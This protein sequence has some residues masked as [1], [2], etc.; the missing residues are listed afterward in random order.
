MSL[1]R[2]YSKKEILEAYLNAV[3]WGNWGAME[4]RG[5]REASRYYLG[6]E[7]EKADPAGIALLVG[8][9]PAPNAY[10]PYHSPEKAL[11][12][13]SFVLRKM[14]KKGI[15]SAKETALALAQPLPVKRPPVQLAEASYF[16]ETVRAEIERRAP[17]GT[18]NEP[19][20]AI[21]T[22]L[23]PRDQAAA[24]AAVRQGLQALE[25]DHRRLRRAEDPLQAA[26]VTIDPENGEV[27]ALVGGRDFLE[28]PYNRAVDALR[29][30]GSL[31]KPF[32]YLAAFQHPDR[33]DSSFWTPTTILKDDTLV[34]PIG[35]KTW[36][37]QDYDHEFRGEVTLRTAL[38][39]SL[40]VPTARVALEVG[41]PRVGKAARMLGVRS[42]LSAVPSLALG[43]SE[44]SLLEMTGAYAGLAA[45]G[46]AHVPTLIRAIRRPDGE[47]VPLAGQQDPPGVGK[48]EAYMIVNLMRGVIDS[49]TGK[50]ARNLGV[51]GDLAGKTGTTDDYRDAWFIGFTPL[52]AIGVWVGFDQTGTIGLSG[53]AAAMPIWA[54]AM[55]SCESPY[56]D[57][58]FERPSGVVTAT[59]DP[60]TGLLATPDCPTSREESFLEGTEPTKECDRH[61]GGVLHRLGRLLGF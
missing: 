18:V 15:L 20:T 19:G 55:R 30:P 44:V 11:I 53:A 17:P 12:R 42:P 8:L 3:Y 31:F 5:A 32:V 52:H 14:E 49:G 4:I 40:N 34:V 22:T 43:T 13:R 28:Y 45:E 16:L 33:A 26:L 39:Q 9:I 24:V 41:I 10:S 37:P 58:V 54:S 25:H 21:F 2:R 6:V 50:E 36:S 61:G 57:G 35:H 47:A 1:E 56:G 23:D 59:I 48:A 46:N 7:L 51:T 27:R 38:E 29:Q 60:E